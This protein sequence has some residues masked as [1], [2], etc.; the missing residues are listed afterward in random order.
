MDGKVRGH[1]VRLKAADGTSG[2]Y[3]SENGH[4]RDHQS[5][6]ND[7]YATRRRHCCP[8]G[9]YAIL[10]VSFRLPEL[11]LTYHTLI[12]VKAVPLFG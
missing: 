8:R 4:E 12:D 9:I 11:C 10:C 2:P 3:V 7:L 1:G 5:R 6:M